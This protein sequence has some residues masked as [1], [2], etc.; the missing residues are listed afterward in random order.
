M[1]QGYFHNALP[2]LSLRDHIRHYTF[3][4]VPFAQTQSMEFRALPTC[5]T[6]IVLFLGGSSLQKKEDQLVRLDDSALTGF[7]S[8]THLFLPAESLRQVMIHF[9]PWG[10][11]PFL[12]F[13]LSDITDTR[14]ELKYIF[15]S[16]LGRLMERLHREGPQGRW[17]EALD[18]FFKKQLRP[19]VQAGRRGRQVA[20]HIVK[21]RGA[22]R[23]SSLAD[24]LHISE[25]TLQRL[26]HN[27]VGI[28]YKFFA[29]LARMEYARQLLNE[30]PQRSL[31][32]LALQAGYY[33]QAHFIHEFQSTY[34]E[35][36]GHFQK[37]INRMAWSRLEACK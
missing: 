28:N 21:A 2:D 4:D 12:D 8:R 7:Y 25:R 31:A 3:V 17:K 1:S 10:V 5:N 18:V 6:Q 34:G 9:T 26:I 27:A 24:E 14:A 16:G 20:N 29:T 23:L 36:P 22:V 35:T 15:R 30:Q 13:P 37:K 11:Q 32:S 33:D 19:A